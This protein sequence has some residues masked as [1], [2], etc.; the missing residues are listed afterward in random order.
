LLPVKP[1]PCTHKHRTQS[2]ALIIIA[3]KFLGHAFASSNCAPTLPQ[4]ILHVYDCTG[5]HATDLRSCQYQL[6]SRAHRKGTALPRPRIVFPSRPHELPE[7]Y[8]ETR[9]PPGHLGTLFD[10][11]NRIGAVDEVWHALFGHTLVLFARAVYNSI[12]LLY[13]MCAHNVHDHARIHGHLSIG[14]IF[15]CSHFGSRSSM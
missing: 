1:R 14:S 7:P 11:P 4:L 3:I 15:S 6:R 12:V 10:M 2:F 13:A 8:S 9:P 5:F